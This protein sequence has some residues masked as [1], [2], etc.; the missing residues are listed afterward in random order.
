MEGQLNFLGKED[1]E[2]LTQSHFWDEDFKP[3]KLPKGVIYYSAANQ[4]FNSLDPKKVEEYKN[5]WESVKPKNNTEIFQRWLFAFMSVHTTWERNV[6]GYEAIKDWTDWFNQNDILEKK[7]VKAG[8]GLHKNRTRY[9]SEFA[10]KFWTNPENYAKV[11]SETWIEFR[12]RLV[13]EILGLGIAKV[14]FSLEM[15]YPNEA[16]VTCMDT[17]LFQLFKLK[18][19]KHAT[20]YKE[21]EQYWLEMCSMWNIPSY[22]ARC[23]YWDKKQEKEDSRYWS[24]VLED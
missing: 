19:E 11:D 13:K 24:Y 4:I 22:I 18:Q 17:H 2:N 6:I 7:L 5:Y 8:V 1:K 14:S 10:K 12:D 21:I 23:V 16:E 15:L 3:I 20:R 9:I